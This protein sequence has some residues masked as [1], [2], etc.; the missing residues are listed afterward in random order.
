MVEHWPAQ[1]GAK[2]GVAL[3]GDVGEEVAAIGQV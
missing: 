2:P 3:V 1:V